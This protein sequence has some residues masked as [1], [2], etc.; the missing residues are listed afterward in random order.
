MF[1][2]YIR[3]K[4][5]IL[6]VKCMYLFFYIQILGNILN[7]KIITYTIKGK[8]TLYEVRQS[9]KICIPFLTSGFNELY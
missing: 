3:K 9:A 8:K 4:I 2:Q 7:Y 5:D 6:S 1:L